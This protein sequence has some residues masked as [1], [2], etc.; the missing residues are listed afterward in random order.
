M[1]RPPIK[2]MGAIKNYC[3]KTQCERCAFGKTVDRYS[4]H[5]YVT[6]LLGETIPCDWEIEKETENDKTDNRQRRFN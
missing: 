2:A 5:Y 6:C 4:D 3:E 1:S